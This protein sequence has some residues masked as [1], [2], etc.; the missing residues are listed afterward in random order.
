[1]P[2]AMFNRPSIQLAAL[3][4]YL[5]REEAGLTVTAFHP[6][7]GLAR[8][9]GPELYRQIA[10]DPWLSEGLYAG[11]LFPERRENLKAFL[12][13]GDALQS[14]GSSNWRDVN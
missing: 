12:T 6:Y 11:L 7:L 2:W 14:H 4:S 1:M 9:I 5:E 8:R 10:L 3:K 13:A